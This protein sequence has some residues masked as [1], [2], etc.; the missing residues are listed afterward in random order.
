MSGAC[1]RSW[2]R[3]RDRRAARLAIGPRRAGVRA[4]RVRRHGRRRRGRAGWCG[5]RGRGRR[6]PIPGTA[7]RSVGHELFADGLGGVGG[8]DA[9]VLAVGGDGLG[10][11]AVAELVERVG[12][13][14]RRLAPVVGELDGRQPGGEGA[15]QP[16]GVDLGELAR[17]TDEHDL[18]LAT[19]DACSRATST[20]IRCR[21]CRDCFRR[22]AMRKL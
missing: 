4:G 8:D 7:R 3:L 15:E 17:V 5:G 2:A 16:A 20:S 9:A 6:N 1:S 11:V 14:V 12:L 18:V 21:R 19:R 22:R 13:P 10:R